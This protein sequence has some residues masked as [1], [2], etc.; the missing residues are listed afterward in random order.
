MPNDYL[1]ALKSQQRVTS[2]ASYSYSSVCACAQLFCVLGRALNVFL[3]SALLN[4]CR[5]REGAR[6]TFAMQVVM[7]FTGLRGAVAVG[8]CMQLEDRVSR[9][10]Y[11]TLV[12]ATC[13]IVVF[14]IV[15]FGTGTWPLLK[16]RPALLSAPYTLSPPAARYIHII[17]IVQVM[18]L[19]C[20]SAS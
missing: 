8:L 5:R 9:A 16:A 4:L 12:N 7:W 6:I 3:L 14:S 13:G 1:L 10:T 19:I 2:S 20:I 11:D 17:L 15:V 18:C